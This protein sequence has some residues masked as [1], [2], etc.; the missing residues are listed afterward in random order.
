MTTKW[1]NLNKNNNFIF[2]YWDP[3]DGED[4]PF[5]EWSE[6]RLLMVHLRRYIEL[7]VA[8]DVIDSGDDNRIDLSVK[9]YFDLFS[10]F[11]IYRIVEWPQS[12][13]TK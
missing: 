9:I 5:V 1:N 7:Y 10:H 3:D 4:D 13:F 6:F 12:S 8:F 2:Y 11:E